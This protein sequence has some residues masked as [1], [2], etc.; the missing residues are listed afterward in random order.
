ML[1]IVAVYWIA[2]E[3]TALGIGQW[4]SRWLF[5]ALAQ[6]WVAADA[7]GSR[8]R[9]GRRKDAFRGAAPQAASTPRLDTSR[10]GRPTVSD[11][12]APGT[13]FRVDLLS[14]LVATAW[15]GFVGGLIGGAISG[16]AAALLAVYG[17]TRA[18]LTTE[19]AIVRLERRSALADLGV[20]FGSF[21]VVS[22]DLK[23]ARLPQQGENDARDERLR[24]R[25]ARTAMLDLERASSQTHDKAVIG[26]AGDILTNYVNWRLSAGGD[27]E[28]TTWRMF[29]ESCVSLKNLMRSELQAPLGQLHEGGRRS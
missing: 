26:A 12:G 9:L 14:A 19:A 22:L 5:I 6:S 28:P 7:G 15:L 23:Y 18:R 10:A 1:A 17:N 25:D 13:S 11:T 24:E 29:W 3:R 20:A 16:V 4:L 8:H 27:E 2:V 21:I